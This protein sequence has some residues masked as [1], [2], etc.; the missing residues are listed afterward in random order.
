MQIKNN[1]KNMET[2]ASMFLV[3][4]VPWVGQFGQCVKPPVFKHSDPSHIVRTPDGVPITKRIGL[5]I[6]FIFFV[7]F[8]VTICLSYRS[9]QRTRRR[10]SCRIWTEFIRTTS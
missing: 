8:C 9:I 6:R 1:C 5:P 7:T 4:V 3:W 2:V 10:E